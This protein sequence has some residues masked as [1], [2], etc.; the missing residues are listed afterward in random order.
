MVDIYISSVNPDESHQ[1]T[2]DGDSKT[3]WMYLYDLEGS[4]VLSDSPICS[5]I[6]P[7]DYNI[8]KKTYKRGDTPQLVKEYASDRAIIYDI[9]NSRLAINWA[10]DG[11]SVVASIDNEPFSFV[12]QG[13]KM[14]YS[15]AIRQSGPFGNPWNEQ[16]Y[17][18]VFG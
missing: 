4:S 15:K 18:K 17:K 2:I 12:V 9:S 5:L 3:V 14:G 11:V 13:K 1:C 6:S 7:I 8:F 16:L 10:D